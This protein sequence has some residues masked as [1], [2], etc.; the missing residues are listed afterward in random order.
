M[1]QIPVYRG[2]GITQKNL[3]GVAVQAPN[4][5]QAAQLPFLQIAQTANNLQ[6]LAFKK[7]ESDLSFANQKLNQELNFNNK[8]LQ[9][10]KNIENELY[11]IDKDYNFQ[12]YKIDE[13]LKIKSQ[14]LET[15]AK[16]NWETASI[17]LSRKNNVQA[18]MQALYPKINELKYSLASSSN[19]E[20]KKNFRSESEVILGMI[21]NDLQ[22]DDKSKQ[23][24]LSEFQ[25]WITREAIDVDHTINTNLLNVSN[26]TYEKEIEQLIYDYNFSNNPIKSQHTLERLL[27]NNGIVYE[28]S[29]NG[30]LVQGSEGFKIDEIKNKLF[31][32]ESN[33]MIDGENANPQKWLNLLEQGYWEDRL[34]N[35]QITSF[36]IKADAEVT[37]INKGI[38][39]SLNSVAT[40]IR[41]ELNSQET[42]LEKVSR[43]N[44]EYLETLKLQADQ[45]I[46]PI[47]KTPIDPMLSNDIQI[48][49]DMVDQVDQF[50]RFP[51]I[52]Q[53]QTIADIE[54]Q[55]STQEFISDAD[56]KKLEIFKSIH[57]NLKTQK[58]EDALNLAQKNDVLG[59]NSKRNSIYSD[60]SLDPLNFYS[61][62]NN[63]PPNER[64]MYDSIE[65]RIDQA[66]YVQ[67]H[68]GLEVPQFLTKSEALQFKNAFANADANQL[69]DLATMITDSFGVH[70]IDVF[71]QINKEAPAMAEIGGHVLNGNIGFALDIAQGHK[72]VQSA[73]LVPNFKNNAAYGEIIVNSIGDSLVDNIAS[74]DTKLAAIENVII[75]RALDEGWL[76]ANFEEIKSDV[77]MFIANNEDKIQKIIN[78]SFGAKYDGDTL[79]S[80]GTAEW[81]GNRIVLPSNFTRIRKGDLYGTEFLEDDELSIVMQNQMTD[82]LLIKAG[83]QGVLPVSSP[84]VDSENRE[85]V[86]I[87][88]ANVFGQPIEVMG[89]EVGSMPYYWDQIEPGKY[90]LALLNP[91]TEEN[92]DYLHYPGTDD[93]FIFDLNKITTD[94]NF[95]Q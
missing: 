40:K 7:Y 30:L 88:A 4:I 75:N 23:I 68:Y 74:M 57:A 2:E 44:L 62:N 41:S 31:G 81:N 58:K 60:D 50:K 35:D 63:V 73:N 77:T 52:Q 86:I 82:D 13:D 19:I 15:Q 46:D 90:L 65:K 85:E 59:N 26:N 17:A 3:P 34:S 39:T 87:N 67:N 69:L 53:E 93:L 79:V 45:L 38:V 95:K 55:Q 71:S 47:T 21:F 24:A 49:I 37:K 1:A 8:N 25:Q 11:K 43:G 84:Y 70:A 51:E 16:L 10:Q 20:D 6:S 9:N 36:A 66:L 54:N 42:I 18:V 22:I 64:E 76:S 5:S 27:G 12:K 56:V 28:M 48:L 89:V 72:R 32:M 91:T 14:E 92:P 83:G 80:G 78:E 33:L 61:D 29:N 94:I